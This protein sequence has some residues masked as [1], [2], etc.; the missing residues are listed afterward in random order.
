MNIIIV[1]D[2]QSHFVE[3]R[4][5]HFGENGEI[6]ADFSGGGCNFIGLNNENKY[7]FSL[8]F[9]LEETMLHSV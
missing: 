2:K 3:Q 5:I 4:F 7:L 9:R 6:T 8:F 1:T